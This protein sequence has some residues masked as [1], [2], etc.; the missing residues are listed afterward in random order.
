[1]NTN[2]KQKTDPVNQQAISQ[3]QSLKYEIHPHQSLSE[4]RQQKHFCDSKCIPIE[5][6]GR[7]E[8]REGE[9][10]EDA[11]LRQFGIRVRRLT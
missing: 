7:L 2:P 5:Y 6:L 1:M 8:L 3:N 4:P 11:T 9:S 10:R